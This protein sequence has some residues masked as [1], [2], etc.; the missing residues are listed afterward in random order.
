MSL[1]VKRPDRTEPANTSILVVYMT[2]LIL[3]KKK[4]PIS[5]EKGKFLKISVTSKAKKPC[6]LSFIAASRYLQAM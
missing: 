3:K 2:Y 5:Y 4:K 1:R 6:K